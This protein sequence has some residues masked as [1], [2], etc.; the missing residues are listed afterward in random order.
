MQKGAHSRREAL[1]S[2]IS[3][4]E[5]LAHISITIYKHASMNDF[6]EGN[7]YAKARHF[8]LAYIALQKS[9]RYLK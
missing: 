4:V 9:L 2:R 6:Q 8:D 7:L 5:V 1:K 3:H